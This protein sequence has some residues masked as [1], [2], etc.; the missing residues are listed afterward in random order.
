[1]IDYITY[2]F[3]YLCEQD[4]DGGGIPFLQPMP[5]EHL[6]DEKNDN[7]EAEKDI[8]EAVQPSETQP[9]KDLQEKQHAKDTQTKKSLLEDSEP[10]LEKE[11]HEESV[12]TDCSLLEVSGTLLVLKQQEAEV[13]VNNT[14]LEAIEPLSQEKQIFEVKSSLSEA[15]EPLAMEKTDKKNFS[16]EDND[17]NVE[18]SELL[19][20]SLDSFEV[21]HKV[22]STNQCQENDLL[23][24][25]GGNRCCQKPTSDKL[26][27]VL[28]PQFQPSP[29]DVSAI[30]TFGKHSASDRLL[31]TLLERDSYYI[32]SEDDDSAE[33]LMLSAICKRCP[34]AATR[35]KTDEEIQSRHLG[36]E[37]KTQ[38][39]NSWLWSSPEVRK[40]KVRHDAVE[41]EA[42]DDVKERQPTIGKSGEQN[43]SGERRVVEDPDGIRGMVFIRPPDSDEDALRI[44][45]HKV[46]AEP[47]GATQLCSA[48]SAEPVSTTQSHYRNSAEPVSA[49]LLY[50]ANCAESVSTTQFYSANSAEPVS[51]TQI[52]FTNSA[53]PVNSTQLYS[54]NSTEPVSSTQLYFTNSAD[55]VSSTQ[56]YSANSAESVSSTSP[57]SLSRH[58]SFRT[59]QVVAHKMFK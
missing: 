48:N 6:T 40:R 51:A 47:V 9:L 55:P 33:Q 3:V 43:G 32:P 41:S 21:S 16:E 2:F 53:E 12:E 13:Q 35:L 52:Y 17:P 26:S 20:S 45:G 10:I 19:V 34:P 42:C 28:L 31:L 18:Q 23:S 1:L 7:A 30:A 5:D 14:V 37:C 49:T 58:V 27:H 29:A 15:A 50:S 4:F 56:F 25:S 44:Q 22:K 24:I 8:L 38:K 57:R 46:S 36:S 54:T 39:R 59:P 11:Q